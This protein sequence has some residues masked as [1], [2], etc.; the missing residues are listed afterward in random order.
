MRIQSTLISSRFRKWQLSD[1]A[2]LIAFLVAL[3]GTIAHAQTEPT[4]TFTSETVTGVENVTPRF[5]W[6]TEPAADSCTA[7]GHPE[8]AGAKPSSGTEELAPITQSATFTLTCEWIG[9]RA[10][11]SWT[12]TT[13][14]TDGTPFND[15]AGIRIHY[16]RAS[17][18]LTET[19]DVM[20]PSPPLSEYVLDG[21]APGRWYFAVRALN[22]AGVASDLSNEATKVVMASTNVNRT[23]SIV[24]NPKPE[25]VTDLSVE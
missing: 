13:K 6:S 22:S 7:S 21:L 8:W 19:K 11:L 10:K 9:G 17:G 16:G 23:V 3:G 24:V 15:P 20:E 5:T 1:R 2:L 4:L 14:N 18:V 25:R 12:P